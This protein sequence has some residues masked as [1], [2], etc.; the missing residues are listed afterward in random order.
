MAPRMIAPSSVP[1]MLPLPPIS[2]A[3]QLAAALDRAK[4]L[5]GP[6]VVAKLDRLS[7]E[8]AFIAG[9][10]AHK[11]PFISVELGADA[12]A[13]MLHLLAALA[14]KERAMISKRT[15]EAL[16]AAKARGQVLGNPRLAEVRALAHAS[17]KAGAD[18]FAAT[19]APAIHAAQAA[20]ASSLRQIAEALNAHGIATPTGKGQWQAMSVRNVLRRI[21]AA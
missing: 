16:A 6:I 21:E 18:A 15:K 12:G 3:P 4:R 5:T 13:L 8:V 11:V 7:R 14:E 1:M 17:A 20:G 2:E 19:V 10:M 9:L